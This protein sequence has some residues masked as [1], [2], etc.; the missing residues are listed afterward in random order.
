MYFEENNVKPLL[1]QQYF[2]GCSQ[3]GSLVE[4]CVKM[5]KRL[6][7]GAIKN[8]VLTYYDFDFLVS[9]VVHLVNRRPIAFK[10]ALRDNNTDFVPEPI[11]PEQL[12]RGYELSSLNLIPDLQ[13]FSDPVYDGNTNTTS[14]QDGYF[15]LRKIRESLVDMYHKEFLGT[16]MQQAVDR[17]C[18]YRPVTH[19]S[20]NVGD[21][22]LIR[23]EHSKRSNYPLGIVL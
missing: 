18:R 7:F 8:N 17:G 13:P 21:I 15:K 14:V 6:L 4:V 9:N 11:T 19:K 23:E 20:L 16:L 1:F 2:K 3:L 22:V 10:D 5:I 12:I